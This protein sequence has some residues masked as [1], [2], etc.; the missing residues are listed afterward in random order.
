[1]PEILPSPVNVNGSG[2]P[3]GVIVLQDMPP[4]R[5]SPN[6]LHFEIVDGQEQGYLNAE[7]IGEIKGASLTDGGV[8]KPVEAWNSESGALSI[9]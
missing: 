3:T 5:T 8:L 4:I 9:N 2:T 6:A 1:M 7:D